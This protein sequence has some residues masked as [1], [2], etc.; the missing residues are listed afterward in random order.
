MDNEV[1]LLN[2]KSVTAILPFF[3]AD[4][5]YAFALLDEDD[6]VGV[7]DPIGLHAV[8]WKSEEKG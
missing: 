2:H 3:T 5:F 8:F 4:N 6:F 1:F 7:F